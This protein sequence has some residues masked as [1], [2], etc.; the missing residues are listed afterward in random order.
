MASLLS[1]QVEQ[2]MPYQQVARVNVGVDSEW[3]R[4]I[5]QNKLIHDQ[6]FV[7]KRFIKRPQMHFPMINTKGGQ[8]L[9]KEGQKVRPTSFYFNVGMNSGVFY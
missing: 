7:P 8:Y 2:L 1:F 3:V 5:L 4:H 6:Y 9:F